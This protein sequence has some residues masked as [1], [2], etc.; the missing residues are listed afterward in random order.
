[1]TFFNSY[2]IYTVKNLIKKKNIRNKKRKEA[3][4]E[5]ALAKNDILKNKLSTM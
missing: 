1:M 3:M 2:L 4:I 5:R